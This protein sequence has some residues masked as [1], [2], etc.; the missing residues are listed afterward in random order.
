M[1]MV[2]SMLDSAQLPCAT[3]F[4]PRRSYMGELSA[5]FRFELLSVG[6]DIEAPDANGCLVKGHAH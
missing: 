4:H 2:C 6:L 5:L 1:V 3:S